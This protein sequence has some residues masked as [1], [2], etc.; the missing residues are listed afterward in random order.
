MGEWGWGGWRSGWD[1][2]WFKYSEW[3]VNVEVLHMYS[4]TRWRA[5]GT[6][7]AALATA[8]IAE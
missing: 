6:C 7:S 1:E 2:R 3:T 8:Q 5:R 4:N